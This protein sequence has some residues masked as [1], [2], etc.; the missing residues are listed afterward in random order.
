MRR[1]PNKQTLAPEQAADPDAIQRAAVALLARRDFASSELQEKLQSQG[2]DG[3]QVA[4]AIAE[5]IERRIVDDARFVE[6]HISYHAN[7]GQGPL[8]IASELKALGLPDGLVDAAL[9]AGPDWCA[10]ARQARIR[11]FGVDPPVEWREKTRQ[12][13]FLQYRGFSSDDI[14]SALGADFDPDE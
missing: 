8:R 11:K 10:L 14:R 3:E 13:R 6:N 7:R 9:K 2:Y 12:V 5:L 4:V 1:R